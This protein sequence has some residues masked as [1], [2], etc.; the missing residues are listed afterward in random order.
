MAIETLVVTEV[1]LLQGLC[2][3]LW[4]NTTCAQPVTIGVKTILDMVFIN[5]NIHGFADILRLLPG[6]YFHT[7]QFKVGLV[8]DMPE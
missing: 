4:A 7:Y 6:G 5:K 3:A 2:I 1:C 8:S